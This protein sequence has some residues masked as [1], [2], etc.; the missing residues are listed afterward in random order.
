MWNGAHYDECPAEAYKNSKLTRFAN[1]WLAERGHADYSALRV[2]AFVDKCALCAD[3]LPSGFVGWADRRDGQW[4]PLRNGV[5]NV[6]TRELVESS[7]QY[8]DFFACPVLT[9]IL[10]PPAPPGRSS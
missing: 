8:I 2:R 6:D 10:M 1:T 5:L 4:L 3:E 9:T 7:G